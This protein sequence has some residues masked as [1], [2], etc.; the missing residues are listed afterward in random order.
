[1]AKITACALGGVFARGAAATTLAMLLLAGCVRFRE[2]MHGW[3]AGTGFVA[4]FVNPVGTQFATE[5]EDIDRTA[6]PWQ[7]ARKLVELKGKMF[8]AGYGP[9]DTWPILA[10]RG[11]LAIDEVLRPNG[12]SPTPE[13][14]RQAEAMERLFGRTP[15]RRLEHRV[16]II[17]H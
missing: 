16:E 3:D 12:Q 13:S 1:M 4:G 15:G 7:R 17:S 11:D 14:E 9:N 10:P 2:G 8:A 6:D 5:L